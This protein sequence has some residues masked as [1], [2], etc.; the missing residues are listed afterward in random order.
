MEKLRPRMIAIDMDG[1]LMGAE[2]KVSAR[3]VAALKA[4]G[5]AG[6]EVVIAT[7]RRHS[8]AM[9]VLR[10]VGLSDSNLLVSSNGAVTRTVGATLVERT[11]LEEET[12]LW[13]CRQLDEFRNALVI[14][15]DL[16]RPDGED[17]RGAL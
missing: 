5:A 16:V 11:F 6:I 14:T 13:L 4:A 12:S 10:A 7:G 3:N 8:Y 2:G 17:A 15:Y 9:K 1:T